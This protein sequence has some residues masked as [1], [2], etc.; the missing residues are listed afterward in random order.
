MADGGWGRAPSGAAV[1]IEGV[2]DEH[3][4]PGGASHRSGPQAGR[5]GEQM[6][7]PERSLAVVLEDFGDIA[8]LQLKSVPTPAIGPHEILVRLIG[9]SVNP[10]E[11]KMRQGLGLPRWLWRKVLGRP[12]V[13]GFDFSG[14]V[15]AVGEAVKEYGIGDEV[16]GAVPRRGAYAEYLVVRPADPH[17]A[18][19]VKPAGETFETA[20]VL[21]FAG[22]VA[23]AGLVSHGGLGTWAP[24]ARVLVVGGSGG[25]GHLAVQMAKRGLQA[26]LVVAV[27][28]S[29]NAG[30]VRECGADEIVPHD[31]VAVEQLAERRP[32]WAGTFDL[33]LDT[34]GIDT[35]YTDVAR[36]LLKS[37]GRFVTAALPQDS[38]GRPGEDRDLLGGLALLL[39][40]LFRSATGRYRLIGGLIGELPS[41]SGFPIMVRWLAEGRLRPRIAARYALA[42]IGLAHRDSERGRTVGKIAV[43][44]L[45]E[46]GR[47][48]QD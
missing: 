18:I 24:D 9:T 7:I 48:G 43:R 35:Y 25:V 40:V 2:V 3:A 39:T 36:K 31:V 16:M 45:P 23:F 6:N 33:I 42:D 41:K 19:A 15:A 47:V 38:R 29:R 12:M 8:K 44:V 1:H 46:G 5:G 28:S 30:F 10:I 27:C 22:L 20:A 4:V 21:P 26:R 11:W 13:L 14:V 32:E 17:T 34:V 37:G